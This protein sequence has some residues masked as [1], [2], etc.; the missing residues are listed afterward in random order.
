MNKKLIAILTLVMFAMTLLPMGA[1][2]ATKNATVGV[3]PVITDSGDYDL[4]S[5]RIKEEAEGDFAAGDVIV[6]TLSSGVEWKKDALGATDAD[7]RMNK[8]VA[9]IN[10]NAINTAN[11]I[12]A[13]LAGSAADI[14]VVSSATARSVNLLIPA[15]SGLELSGTEATVVIPV[16]AT[17]ASVSSG[18]ITLNIEAPGTAITEGDVVVG[19]FSTGSATVKALSTPTKGASSTFGT[20][21]ITENAQ[22]ALTNGNTVEMRLVGGFEWDLAAVD[23]STSIVGSRTLQFDVDAAL[24]TATKLVVDVTGSAGGPGIIDFPTHVIIPA[25]TKTGDIKVVFSKELSGDLV[26]GKYADFGVNLTAKTAKELVAG[27]DDQKIADVT[28]K[29]QVAGSLISGRTVI[30]ELPADT[31]W[32]AAPSLQPKSDAPA[33]A[34]TATLTNDNRTAQFTMPALS[35][36]TEYLLDGETIDVAPRFKGDVVVKVSG[37]AG[38]SGEVVVATVTAPVAVDV[39]NTKLEI[40][41]QNQELADIYITENVKEAFKRPDATFTNDYFT[42]TLDN[43]LEFSATPKVEVVEGNLEIDDV[44]RV[45]GVVRIHIKNE[46]TTPSKLKVTGLKVTTNRSVP[47]GDVK[48]TIAGDAIVRN[49]FTTITWDP[50]AKTTG[51]FKI[52]T[53]VTPAGE[54]VVQP[55]T[56]TVGSTIY[57]IDGVEND[58]DVAPYIKSDRT[59]FPV[60]YVANALGIN[61]E[62]VVWD[63][64]QRTVTIFRANR[65]VQVAIGSTTML[66]NGVPVTM[67][68]AP[69][70]TAER[71]MLPIRFVAQGLGVNVIW[72]AATQTVT[73]N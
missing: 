28:I 18:D 51:A 3:I 70:I 46:S 33:G 50:S 5:V 63:P 27:I 62:N 15:G 72:D 32:N 41:K 35:G 56:M 60:R 47:E 8:L 64:A 9:N 40:G 31:R 23:Y 42:L 36:T 54:N 29:D 26:I 69:E 68:V 11:G 71:T 13:G 39:T 45:A 30:F 16:E 24:S 7:K 65:I 25:G 37:T 6:L 10:A 2:A 34:V 57:T 67:D 49:D 1:F 44:T 48:V 20:I 55:V 73:L 66:V 38:A 12:T 14:Q 58:M 4:A 17:V 53:V 22:G 59:Y 43:G 61:D 52:A 19:R 21:R